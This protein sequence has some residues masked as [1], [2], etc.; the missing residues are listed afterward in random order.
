MPIPTND[1]ILHLLDRFE[2]ET[3]E[4]IESEYLEFKPWRNAKEERRLAAEYIVC[5]ANSEGG[6]LIFGVTDKIRG[7]AAAIHGVGRYNLDEWR[8]GLYAA[9][10]PSLEIEISEITVPE[11]TGKL[12]VVRIPKGPTPPYGTAEG[13]FKTRVGKNCMPLDPHQVARGRVATGAVDWS[14][15][16]ADGI[17]PDDLDPVEI[18][19]ARAVLR[20][21]NPE[22]ELLKMKDAQF[23]SGLEAVRK[24]R[25]TNAGLLLFGKPEVLHEACPQNQV[26]YV[27]QTSGTTVARNDV[28]RVGLLQALERVEQ[29]FQGPA[30]PEEELSLGLFKLR[31]ASFPLEVVR[32]T[33]LNAVTHRDYS[34][35]G[36][37]LI[38][39]AKSELV[40]T[41]PGGFIGGITVD[42]ILRHDAVPR[43]RTL[44]NAFLKLRLV[45]ASG[46]GRGKI[47]VPTLSYGKRMPRYETD[48][49]RVSLHLFNGSYDK[50][51]A[52]LVAK[53][54]Q[55]G[56]EIGLDAL[57]VLA[58]LKENTYLDTRSA[59]WL[60]KIPAD[61]AASIL[62]TL[63]VPPTGILERKGQT[64]A[65][66]YHLAK[67]VAKDLLGKAAYTRTRGLNPIRYAEMVKT[68]VR[69]HGTITPKECRELLGLGSSASA[70][71]EVSRYLKKWSSDGGFLRAVGTTPQTRRY[72][73]SGDD[74]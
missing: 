23:L 74:L 42:N 40:V 15:Q 21:K 43:N 67:G 49:S 12:L 55:D 22:S 24:G 10:N 7:R 65:A 71:V 61:Q 56:K 5:F 26:H 66:T 38:R 41:N 70:R 4:D 17:R 63:A 52:T 36:E 11:G 37:V 18:S 31:I 51:F 20:S 14:G 16:T 68:F 57:L 59:A 30:N 19:R 45:E 62:E 48:G 44:A 9:V 28:F 47:F 3:A 33:V 64:R 35:P 27:Y 1:E 54:N 25:V 39:Q 13:L 60:L 50:R 29:L 72:E 8:R 6:V 69:D 53:W 46:T 34:D 58:Y 73:L 32:E 2:T